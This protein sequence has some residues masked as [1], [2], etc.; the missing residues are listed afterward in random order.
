MRRLLCLLVLA[1]APA[2]S[3]FNW[4]IVA[5]YDHTKVGGGAEDE[6]SYPT[7]I[8]ISDASIKTVANGGHVTNASGSDILAF[9][10]SC[11]TQLPS[12]LEVYDGTNGILTLWVM[13]STVSHSTNGAIT[14]CAGNASPPARTGGVWDANFVGVWHLGNGTTLSGSDSTANANNGTVSGAS[15]T[16]GKVDGAVDF[17]TSGNNNIA[18]PDSSSLNFSGPVTLETWVYPKDASNYHVLMVKGPNSADRAYGMYLSYS[19]TSYLY[20]GFGN[21]PG[22]PGDISLSTPWA[23]NSWNHIVV[24]ADG[25]SIKAY[26]QGTLAGTAASSYDAVPLSE[27]TYLGYSPV[28]GNFNLYGLL[29]ETRISKSARSAGWISTDYQNQSAPGNIGS[30]GFWTYGSWT[31]LGTA[32]VTVMPIVM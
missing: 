14:L 25:S 32:H 30:A 18:I 1:S 3:A 4:K 21:A 9:S 2:F 16:S 31:S 24:T 22:L 13:V 28:D 19:G 10:D 11:T 29:D 7:L 12:E 15:A 6:A 8:S 27:T 23:I 5:T 17:G 20:V 26:V